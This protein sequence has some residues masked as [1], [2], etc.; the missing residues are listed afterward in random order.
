M[1]RLGGM[2]ANELHSKIK[3]WHDC[4]NEGSSLLVPDEDNPWRSRSDTDWNL[5]PTLYQNA[6]FW[7]S[8]STAQNIFEFGMDRAGQDT[9]RKS[10]HIQCVGDNSRLPSSSSSSSSWN[11]Q[12]V[13]KLPASY[14]I[15]LSARFPPLDREGLSS[16]SLESKRLPCCT[17][18]IPPTPPNL[19][20]SLPGPKARIPSCSHGRLLVI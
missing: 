2:A 17:G 20:G 18:P 15:I 11:R 10:Y 6:D 7:L 5:W 19:P 1:A 8:A 3:Q 13:V 12:H 14:G 4:V 16:C 9:A